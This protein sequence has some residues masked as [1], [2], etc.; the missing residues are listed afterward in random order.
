LIGFQQILKLLEAD[1]GFRDGVFKNAPTAVFPSKFPKKSFW[2]AIKNNQ[3][4]PK[5]SQHFPSNFMF[6]LF[7]GLQHIR[8]KLGQHLGIFKVSQPGK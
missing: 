6:S 1:L 4:I 2:E 5:Y 3:N 8:K 7:I